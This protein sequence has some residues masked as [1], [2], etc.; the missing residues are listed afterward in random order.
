MCGW[1]CVGVD[2]RWGVY[3]GVS[4]GETSGRIR[5]PATNTGNQ[6]GFTVAPVWRHLLLLH[7][8]PPAAH[9]SIV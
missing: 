5:S 6:V 2:V 1:V 8:S 9:Y 4:Q 3:V 7:H